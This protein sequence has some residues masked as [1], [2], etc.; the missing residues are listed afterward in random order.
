MPLP[1]WLLCRLLRHRPEHLNQFTRLSSWFGIRCFVLNWFNSYLSS[2]TFRIKFDNIIS[3]LILWRSPK[4]ISRSSTLQHLPLS[5]L[6]SPLFPEAP[7]L[8]WWHLTLLLLCTTQL[9]L[10]HYSHI[11]SAQQI[12]S[13]MTANLSTLNSTTHEFMLI[14]LKTNLPK[15]T[16]PHSTP[17]TLLANLA[18]SLMNTLP[19][20]TKFHLSIIN[21]A[22][23][24][25]VNFAVSAL[26]LTTQQSL[27]H[28]YIYWSLQTRLL[29]YCNYSARRAEYWKY[30]TVFRRRSRALL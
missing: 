4:L 18:S 17:P 6:S 2:H 9:R 23:I 14:G 5:A 27:Y 12:S 30:I 8:C 26:T 25:F 7:P 1:P 13:W 24:T 28:C 10:K 15:Y 21:P 3:S 11:Q 20:L 29:D 19:F 22:I 16:T